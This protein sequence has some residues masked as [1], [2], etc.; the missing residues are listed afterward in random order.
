MVVGDFPGT[1]DVES[2]K[3]FSGHTGELLDDL[4]EQAGTRRSDCYLT[5]VRKYQPPNNLWAVFGADEPPL[6]KQLEMLQQ[7]IDA[8]KPNCILALGD[9]ALSALT[10]RAGILKWRGSILTH[11]NG[12]P[13]VVSSLHPKDLSRSKSDTDGTGVHTYAYKH[14]MRLDFQRAVAQSKFPDLR[15]PERYLQVC[16][17]SIDLQR[18][19]ERNDI[20][21]P[22]SVDIES[23]RCIPVCI[24]L[25]FQRGEAI[26]I[27]LFNKLSHIN[28]DG[29]S[30]QELTFIWKDL[31]ELLHTC[32]VV[33]QNFKYDDAK[34]YALGLQAY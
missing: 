8:I 30:T 27:P 34:L 6:E 28:Y 9:K 19:I 26:S 12:I 33:G 1:Q 32:K 21:K 17:S 11:R 22:L 31:G 7:E 3:I 24:G 10:G 5:T 20:R 13:K 18:F 2:G 15:L 29:L 16:R 25:S 14:V 4:L 23:S